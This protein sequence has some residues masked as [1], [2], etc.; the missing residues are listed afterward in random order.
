MT[1]EPDSDRT[2]ETID[3]RGQKCP[4]PVIRLARRARLLGPGDRVAV[5]ADDP[6]ARHDIPAWARLKGHSVTATD[7]GAHTA[8]DIV[9]GD[10][11]SG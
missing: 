2:G 6:A 10:P 9:I 7:H 5:L 11:T 1:R 8:Y 4:M 3:A